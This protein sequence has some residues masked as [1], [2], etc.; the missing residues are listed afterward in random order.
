[1]TVAA[2]GFRV[3]V[4]GKLG[5][6]PCLARELEGLYTPEQA[7]RILNACLRAHQETWRPGLRFADV[8]TARGAARVAGLGG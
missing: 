2:R 7:L 5:R 1:M 4:G 8:V 3:L 6:R